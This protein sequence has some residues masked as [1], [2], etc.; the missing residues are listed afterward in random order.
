MLGIG[1]GIIVIP[2]LFFLF[3]IFPTPYPDYLSQIIFA[4]SNGVVFLTSLRN[5]YN[6]YK[7][8]LISFKNTIKV[9]S[10]CLIGGFIGGNL[11]THFSSKTLKVLF[12]I[13]LI[14]VC[15]RMIFSKE[16]VQRDH[17]YNIKSVKFPSLTLFLI[18]FFVGIV[19]GF[20]GLGGGVI[21]V[22]LLTTFFKIP[23]LYAQGFSVSLIPFNT[24]GGVVGYTVEGVK[25][26]GIHFPYFGFINLYVIIICSI[27]SM[28]FT[29]F[30]L[31]CAKKIN[32]TL[33]RRIFAILLLIVAVKFIFT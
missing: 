2:S 30:G 5:F 31:N 18:G 16:P 19:A 3:H 21:V 17:G 28:I 4:S 24:F 11:G 29:K 9:A 20:F 15:I 26:V 25:K 23:I 22:P 7:S 33:L 6:Y 12:S 32:K 1:G 10:F 27:F 8:N 13:F 14:L